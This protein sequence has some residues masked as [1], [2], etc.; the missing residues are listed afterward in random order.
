MTV[1]YYYHFISSFHRFCEYLWKNDPVEY[2]EMVMLHNSENAE[3]AKVIEDVQEYA[4][5]N[6]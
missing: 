5:R 6:G 1:K 2:I 4:N 3:G